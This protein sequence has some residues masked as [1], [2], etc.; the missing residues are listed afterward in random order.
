MDN[1]EVSIICPNCQC[2]LGL[3]EVG[4]P[5]ILNL[6]DDLPAGSY[7]AGRSRLVVEDATPAWRENEYR[8]NQ[9][10]A[11]T[12]SKLMAPIGTPRLEPEPVQ[13]EDDTD[14]KSA[15]SSD[16]KQRGITTT[17]DNIND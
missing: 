9:Q 3:D 14:L 13:L 11:D 2:R 7:R 8:Y 15:V 4:E 12:S 5:T 16:L 1:E 6:S 10:G 17:P